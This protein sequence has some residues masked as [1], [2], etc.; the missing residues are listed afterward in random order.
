MTRSLISD[1]KYPQNLSPFD[2]IS[3]MKQ[4][5]ASIDLGSHTAGLL[6]ALKSGSSG[7]LKPLVRKRA[8]IGLA[9]GFDHVR[10]RGNAHLIIDGG[11]V[12]A[13]TLVVVGILKY[14]WSLRKGV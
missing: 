9:G 6:I 2:A 12:V 11:E 14:H 4:L 13:G 5:V 1:R 8:Y 7:R 10:V 3:K